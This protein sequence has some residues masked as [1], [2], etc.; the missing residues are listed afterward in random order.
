M[1]WWLYVAPPYGLLVSVAS[2]LVV[3]PL[4]Q[5]KNE[6]SI[7]ACASCLLRPK[8]FKTWEPVAGSRSAAPFRLTGEGVEGSE[9]FFLLRL[10]PLWLYT[11]SDDWWYSH[12]TVYFKQNCLYWEKQ[13]QIYTS[14]TLRHFGLYFYESMVASRNFMTP[15]NTHWCS[16]RGPCWRWVTLRKMWP[17]SHA[18]AFLKAAVCDTLV[19]V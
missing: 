4:K 16:S 12:L 17:S 11:T 19:W 9:V 5:S 8:C 1:V 6:T 18:H 13:L 15:C 10:R 14:N 7:W 2:T 3:L